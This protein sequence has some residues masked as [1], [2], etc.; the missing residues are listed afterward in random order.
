V[1]FASTQQWLDLIEL[2]APHHNLDHGNFQNCHYL[3]L[4]WICQGFGTSYTQ[5]AISGEKEN[6][7][8]E[9]RS[10]LVTDTSGK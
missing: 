1:D 4:P 6:W 5:Q 2:P 10:K 7:A 9:E 8:Q 3:K